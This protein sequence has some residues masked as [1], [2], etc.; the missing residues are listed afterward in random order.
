MTP[1]ELV[2]TTFLISA[3]QMGAAEA[4]MVMPQPL[5]HS[6]VLYS[7]QTN[8]Q[9]HLSEG[10]ALI[11]PKSFD[12][13]LTT[14]RSEV[15]TLVWD[16][17]SPYLPQ[18]SKAAISAFGVSSEPFGSAVRTADEMV[19]HYMVSVNDTLKALMERLNVGEW[20]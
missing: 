2:M 1:N 15:Q 5:L 3:T 16:M 17:Y 14:E 18:D 20:Y 7:L 12:L 19:G 6:P 11:E 10:Y 13:H 4:A 9:R 8:T